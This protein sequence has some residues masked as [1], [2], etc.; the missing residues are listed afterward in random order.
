MVYFWTAIFFLSSSGLFLYPIYGE[1]NRELWPFVLGIGVVLNIVGCFR[2]PNLKIGCSATR[3]VEPTDNV[4][5]QTNTPN[6]LLALFLIPVAFGI[7][8]FR[9]PYTIPLYTLAAGIILTYALR[10]S[11][12]TKSIGQ[13]VL[14]SGLILIF[15]TACI[16][17][18]FKIAARYHEIDIFTPFFYLI[19]KALGFSC[20]YSQNTLFVQTTQANIDITTTWERLGLF[21]FMMFVTGAITLL[22]LLWENGSKVRFW[23]NTGIFFAIIVSYI[24]ARYVFMT[25]IFLEISKAEVFWKPVIVASS[26]LPLPF[27]LSGFMKTRDNDQDNTL[28]DD[29]SVLEETGVFKSNLC[30]SAKCK[31]ILYPGIAALFFSFS[32][33]GCF[34]FQDSG[35]LKKGRVLVD[36]FHSNW[37]W[38]DKKFDTQWFGIQSV[39]NYYCFA[40][41]LDHFYSVDRLREEISQEILNECDVLIIK[42]PTVS[43]SEKEISDI[44]EFVKNGGGLYL[45]G[46]HTNVFGTTINLN[47]LAERFGY[48]FNYDA[49]Y[50][51]I[52]S[53]LHFHKQNRLFVHPSIKHMPYFLFATSCSMEAPFFAE[54]TMIASNLKTMYLDYARGGY[55][56]EKNKVLNYTF[57]LFLQSSGVKYGKG[58]VMAFSDSTCFSNF[59]MHIPGKPEYALGVVDWLNRANK[60]NTLIKIVSIAVMILS[61]GF[62]IYYFLITRQK[63]SSAGKNSTKEMVY[64]FNGLVNAWPSKSVRGLLFGG[65]LGVCSSVL[66]FN[67]LNDDQ[68]QLPEEH[69]PMIKIG[70]EE[71]FCNFHIP[72]LRLLHNPVIDFQTFYVWTQRLNYYP[73]LFSL[74]QSLDEFD[75]VVM[76]HPREYFSDENLKK[77]DDYVSNGGKLL[78]IDYPKG[79]QSTANQVMKRFGMEIDYKQHLEKVTIYDNNKKAG[80][81]KSFSPVTGGTPLL[82]TGDKKSF[83]SMQ[84]HGQGLVAAMACS[85]SFTNEEMGNT[86]AIPDEHQQFLY[87]LEFWILTSLIN[88]HFDPLSDFSIEE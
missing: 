44:E 86:E 64:S 76:V 11:K 42:T 49:T 61:G 80:T 69:T 1:Q 7:F 66:L 85:T 63:I 29:G 46:D 75:M 67:S 37:E 36:E 50:D 30:K 68:Y 72:S 65:L 21:P 58:R 45:I 43:F 55:F 24:A 14:L 28:R 60:Y 16:I 8:T 23:K 79:L 9:F 47:P 12:V 78:L 4:S 34:W 70:F 54:D 62:I 84:K 41:Y 38:S 31:T 51:L 17:P 13:G 59:Y 32:L 3:Q 20:A 19:L 71:K 82:E 88:G 77:I 25:I 35:E 83:I 22:Y 18:Y 26:F 52:D 87:K 81:I 48:W 6:F 33:I 40:E 56:P 57:G 15:Q 73:S 39:Y 10:C 74:D 2:Y 5:D 53:D 27:I